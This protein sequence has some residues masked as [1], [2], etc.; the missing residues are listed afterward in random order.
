MARKKSAFEHYDFIRATV[1]C[2]GDMRMEYR[3]KNLT[4]VGN[5]SHDED[6]SQWTDEEIRRC[7]RSLLSVDENDP[8]VVEVIHD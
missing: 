4:V 1:D 3:L 5:Q 2:D 8:V 7:V 6:V